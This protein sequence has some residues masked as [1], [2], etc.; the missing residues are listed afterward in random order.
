MSDIRLRGK[1]LL[2]LG[3]DPKYETTFEY[4]VKIPTV[5]GG[6]YLKGIRV[7][8]KKKRSVVNIRCQFFTRKDGEYE[9]QTFGNIQTVGEIRGIVKEY[10]KIE[11]KS[12]LSDQQIDE[13]CE[14]FYQADIQHRFDTEVVK[15][16]KSE[17]PVYQI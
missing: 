8:F 3:F 7:Q 16:N 6:Y 4:A 14:R 12:D 5:G 11:L 9:F 2:F 10:L 1:H 13:N 17:T 15:A